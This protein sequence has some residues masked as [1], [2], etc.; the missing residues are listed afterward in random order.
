MITVSV[1]WLTRMST[2]DEAVL[3]LENSL[4]EQGSVDDGG[5]TVEI[6][7]NLLHLALTDCLKDRLH[8]EL[9]PVNNPDIR[10]TFKLPA[11]SE[12]I[13]LLRKLGERDP[14]SGPLPDSVECRTS[15]HKLLQI[16]LY[17]KYYRFYISGKVG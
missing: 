4:G 12:E 3:H 2:L 17:E 9:G 1:L 15:Y 13:P 11:A 14:E 8:H 5:K 7:D 16:A 10:N 6:D